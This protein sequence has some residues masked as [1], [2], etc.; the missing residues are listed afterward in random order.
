MSKAI[1]DRL[2]TL[3]QELTVL[4][5]RVV[6][7]R[8]NTSNQSLLFSEESETLKQELKKEQTKRKR[9]SDILSRNIMKI[10]RII[11]REEKNN[12]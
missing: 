4:E 7:K 3:S 11:E 1:L 8:S 2:E 12:A 5:R 9:V 6:E 10:E